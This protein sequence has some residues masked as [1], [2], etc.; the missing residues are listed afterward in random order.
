MQ[1][2]STNLSIKVNKKCFLFL[3]FIP[4]VLSCKSITVNYTYGELVLDNIPNEFEGMYIYAYE[5]PRKDY[6]LYAADQITEKGRTT[7]SLIQNGKAN[8]K[9]WQ[10]IYRKV[11]NNQS[12]AYSFNGSGSFPLRFGI[13]ATK[14]SFPTLGLVSGSVTHYAGFDIQIV[15]FLNGRAKYTYYDIIE[16]TDGELKIVN[17]PEEYNGRFVWAMPTNAGTYPHLIGVSSIDSDDSNKAYCDVVENG[18][19]ILKIYLRASR[20]RFNYNLTEVKAINLLLHSTDTIN[21]RSSSSRIMREISISF[22]DGK[23]VY[24]W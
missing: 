8:L 5:D 20:N 13:M 18:T 10:G 19:V 1:K 22:V 14:K 15:D 4:L 2:L 16:E 3:I 7:P 17:I 6:F 23:A 21:L 9:V 24:Q 12:G 11:K